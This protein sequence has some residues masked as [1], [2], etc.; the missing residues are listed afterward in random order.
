M[1]RRVKDT[2][3]LLQWKEICQLSAVRLSE[4][5][6]SGVVSPFREVRTISAEIARHRDAQTWCR[7]MSKFESIGSRRPAK[8][9]GQRGCRARSD[10]VALH[11]R[12]SI[13]LFPWS[14]FAI[15]ASLELRKN[16]NLGVYESAANTFCQ[17]GSS[18]NPQV[19]KQAAFCALFAFV[20]MLCSTL[21][22]RSQTESSY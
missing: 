1:E 9:S 7:Q 21:V 19:K 20:R 5:A 10:S 16:R 4:I 11:L 15:V 12:S 18:G 8:R 22:P 14:F 17:Q 6:F 13:A 2:R 3:P